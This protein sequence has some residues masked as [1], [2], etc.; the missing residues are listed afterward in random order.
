MS[1]EEESRKCTSCGFCQAACP[2]FAASLRP[3][4][5]TRGKMLLLQEVRKGYI[6][7]SG[8]LTDTFYS[9]TTCGACTRSCPRLL[10]GAEVVEEVR[11]SLYREGLLPEEF[12]L[13][14]E[15]IES[16]GNVYGHPEGERVEVYPRELREL[17]GKKRLKPQAE[18]LLFLGCLPSYMDLKIVPSLVRILDRAGVD[19]TLLGP[20]ESCCG[21]PLHL[22]GSDRFQEQASKVAERIRA[23]G[24]RTLLTPCAGCYK[25]FTQLYPSVVELPMEVR[26]TVQFLHRLVSEKGLRFGKGVAR[27]LTYH[28]PCDLGRGCG[29]FEEP[30]LLLNAIPG[31]RLMEMPKN[32]QD[33]RCCGGGGGLSAVH[34]E[35]AAEIAARRVRDALGVGAEG[36]VSGCPSCKDQL[37][38]G[39]RRI[40]K[41]ERGGLV[42]MDIVEAVAG[43]IE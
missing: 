28:D 33:G 20:E 38:K 40:P 34:P 42:V 17:A 39:A 30:R 16:R 41:A 22:M 37:R 24:A 11:R 31:V 19:Y 5:N 6:T 27:K 4:Y 13:L 12:R 23:S 7:L 25:T 35:L 10:K 3:A 32:R 14:Q 1:M 9:C 26:H 21:L 15:G 43:A 36:I 2:V 18:V 29:I 8:E